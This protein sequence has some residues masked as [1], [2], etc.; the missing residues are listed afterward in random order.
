MTDYEFLLELSLKRGYPVIES[1]DFNSEVKGLAVDG[2][3]GL[4]SEIET[5]RE[6][7]C[8]LAE[9]IA[10][11]ELNT[12]DI[13]D[14]SN[15]SN[16]KQEMRAHKRAVYNLVPFERLI[17]AIIDL[18]DETSIYSLAREL[19]VTEEFIVEAIEIYSNKYGERKD[20]GA[21]VVFFHPFRVVEK[22]KI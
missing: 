7:K 22:Q 13:L 12:G 11:T 2:G 1:F 15:A 6:R 5:E 20:Y 8:I 18:R 14:L 4:S 21:Y 19:D 16:R 9:E 17:D 3:I 10:H